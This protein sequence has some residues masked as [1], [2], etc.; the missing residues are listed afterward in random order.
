MEESSAK[1]TSTDGNGAT[2]KQKDSMENKK[3]DGVDTE[4]E[5][6]LAKLLGVPTTVGSCFQQ[7]LHLLLPNV[8]MF[9]GYSRCSN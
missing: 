9:A 1:P 7:H 2:E 5:V 8:G 4:L 6:R 3:G